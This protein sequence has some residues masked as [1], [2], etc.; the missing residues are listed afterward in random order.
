MNQF[1]AFTSNEMRNHMTPPES[2]F[3]YLA[4]LEEKKDLAA[5]TDFYGGK[6]LLGVTHTGTPIYAT[7]SINKETLDMHL[8]LTHTIDT[9]RKS[10]LCPRRVT[11]GANETA[12]NLD[13]AMR[14][15]SKTDMGEVTQRTLDYIEDL[16]NIN[17]SKIYYENGKCTTLMFM[18]AAHCI[19][20]GSHEKGKI[21]WIDVMEA[22]NLPK[23]QY[24]TV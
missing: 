1:K 5:N 6:R 24:F 11:I 7:L 20:S 14:P 9:I 12:P 2:R 22:W 16:I 3:K 4:W 15:A 19:Y 18:K 13:H 21:R 23:G 17:E 8:A 10:E